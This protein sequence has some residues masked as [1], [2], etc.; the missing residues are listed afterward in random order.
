M[1]GPGQINCLHC[2][3]N[4]GKLVH[5]NTF[6][7]AEDDTSITPYPNNARLRQLVKDAKA[8]G[9]TQAEMLERF[10]AGQVRPL[11][12][13]AFKAWLADPGAVRFRPMADKFLSHAQKVLTKAARKA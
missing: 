6:S 10:N 1:S 4:Q 12:L 9:L 5:M 8:A 13:S 2:K 7:K 11:T 3:L